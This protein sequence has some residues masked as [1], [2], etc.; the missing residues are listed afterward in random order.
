MFIRP[1]AALRIVAALFCLT[2]SSAFS[3]GFPTKPIRL[4]VPFPPGTPPDVAARLVSAKLQPRL[5][6]PIVIDNKPGASGT[7]AMAEFAHQPADGYTLFVLPSP[8]V[9]II[10]LYPKAPLNLRTDVVAVAQLSWSYNVLAVPPS[11]KYRT[12]AD[13][14]ADLKA[15][16]RQLTYA[17]GGHGTPAHM[18]AA[19]LLLKTGT[20]AVHV[21][22]NQFS[23]AISDLGTGRVDF[24][25]MNAALGVPQVMA[26]RLRALA[27]TSPTRLADL[28]ETPTFAEVGLPQVAIRGW[29]GIVALK[30]TPK[31]ALDRLGKEIVAA[32]ADPD[33]KRDML[34]GQAVPATGDA[35][36]FNT[37][38]TSE[39]SLWTQVVKDAG[40][41]LDK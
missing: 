27:V 12:V 21:P 1:L 33:L 10:S 13:L 22:Y 30:G 37:L 35:E 39:L 4:I 16:P 40:I 17:S 41:T 5:G 2:L 8:T 36:S 19:L 7:I 28:P 23:Q 26:S 31:E 38:L 11:S 20:E 29:D 15:R 24:M 14:V 32:L 9:S 18:V 6:Q 3:Q 34:K 25:I